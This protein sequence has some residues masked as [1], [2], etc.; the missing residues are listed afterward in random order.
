MS[1]IPRRWRRRQKLGG[2]FNLPAGGS[3]VVST[4]IP[5]GQ[6]DQG[7]LIVEWTC[8]G[9]NRNLHKV[10]VAR[11]AAEFGIEIACPY[12]NPDEVVS[13]GVV[14]SARKRPR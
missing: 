10:V 3:A 9:C 1:L 13:R 14:E 7:C 4:R 11:D 6:L 2:R 8:G 5:A 12:C